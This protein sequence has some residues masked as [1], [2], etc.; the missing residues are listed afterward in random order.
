M[1]LDWNDWYA[2]AAADNRHYLPSYIQRIYCQTF[3]TA[4]QLFPF[5][6]RWIQFTPSQPILSRPILVL[7][8]HLHLGLAN[9]IFHLGFQ[10]GLSRTQCVFHRLSGWNVRRKLNG[11]QKTQL[12]S[13]TKDCAALCVNKTKR[14]STAWYAALFSTERSAHTVTNMVPPRQGNRTFEVL[15]LSK[16]QKFLSTPH[17]KHSANRDFR[18]RPCEV[19]PFSR[20]LPSRLVV[21]YRLFRT[22]YHSHFQGS[23]CSRRRFD[24]WTWKRYVVSKSR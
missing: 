4:S 3:K 10:A 5:L 14:R 9:C 13:V 23:S 17:T 20:M 21:A 2:V 18:L 1:C 22:T 11:V 15:N 24:Q 7:P 16:W 19:E 8:L 6:A 12:T